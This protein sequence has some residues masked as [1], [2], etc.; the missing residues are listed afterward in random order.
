MKVNKR[1]LSLFLIFMQSCGI[2]F[3]QGQGWFLMLLLLVIN[4]QN[5]KNVNIKYL[6]KTPY[7]LFFFFA[8]VI[9][10]SMFY[11]YTWV[12][13]MFLVFFATSVFLL[14]YRNDTTLFFD[15][16]YKFLTILFF[17]SLGHILVNVLFQS[18][19]ITTDLGMKPKTFIYLF[20]FNRVE[21]FPGFYRVQGLAWEPGNW[22][23][24]L[25]L[26][27]LM[28]V[29]K[30]ERLFKLGLI[31]LCII[32]TFSTN[33]YI[34]L[35]LNV[36]NLIIYSK[37]KFIIL[38]IVGL[39]SFLLFPLV[40][41][42]IQEKFSG[43]KMLSGLARSRDLYIGAALIKDSPFLGVN[44]LKINSI[45]IVKEVKS[46]T[47]FS[48]AD[49]NQYSAYDGFISDGYLNGFLEVFLLWGLFFGLLLYYFFYKS[50][51]F[52]TKSFAFSFCII[53]FLSFT[54]EPITQTSFF[55]LFPLSTLLFGKRGL[56]S[57]DAHA[58]NA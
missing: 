7:F 31:G 11:D 17:Y 20:Y 2:S 39:V 44:V 12:L 9:L 3:F 28:S 40:L 47:F 29:F 36:F 41:S 50:P 25:N 18:S 24:F 22:Q 53:S 35:T 49:Q 46:N 43:D 58:I 37:R 45:P 15:D 5:I 57:A 54:A 26:Y 48:V 4:I 23:L 56:Y 8:L 32:S 55:Y 6:K 51:L 33:G 34:L 16:L 13:Y 21:F 14:N 38:P 1:I 10:K 27:F 42:N 30:K 19:L 52:L